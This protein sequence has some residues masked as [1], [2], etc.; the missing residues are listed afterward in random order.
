MK[1]PPQKTPFAATPRR[2]PVAAAGNEL[3]NATGRAR[4][5]RKTK[6]RQAASVGVAQRTTER[7]R[8]EVEVTLLGTVSGNWASICPVIPE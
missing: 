4:L 1:R 5:F 6:V 8:D 7:Q 3:P 2:E